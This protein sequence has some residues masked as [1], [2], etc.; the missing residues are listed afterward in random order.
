L[1]ETRSELAVPLIVG[2]Q[3]LGVLDVQSD[4]VGAFD[5]EDLFI[6][7][8]LA[9]QIAIAIEDARL[10]ASQKEEAW[11]LNVLLQVAENLSAT[12]NLDD[13]LETV[14]RITP[15][16]VGVARCAI[17][18]YDPREQVFRPAKSYGL[19][20]ALQEKFRRLVFPL[21]SDTPDV[22]GE[23]W[24]T[25]SPVQIENVQ[26][27]AL[28]DQELARTFELESMLIVP[29]MT[30]GEIVGAMAVDQGPSPRRFTSHEMQVLMGIANQAAVAIV[31]AR[32]NEEAEVKKRLDYELGLAR[33]IQASFL[34]DRVPQVAGF[35]IASAWRAAREVSG[36]F[37]DFMNL[38][39]GRV[40]FS[41]ADVSD[42]GMP[43]SLFM[44]LTRTL[45]RAMAIGKPTP[46]EAL[47]RANDLII[48][49]ARTDMFVTA[50]YG[51][52]DPATA[53]FSFTNAGHNPPLWFRH[54]EEVLTTLR[55]HGLALGVHPNIDLPEEKVELGPGD[56][57]LM[58]T[59]GIT[60]ALNPREEEFGIGRLADLV[61][62]NGQLS[63][64]E[65]VSEILRAVDDFSEG[66]PQF[67]DLTMA[68]LKRKR[69]GSR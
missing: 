15:I 1:D 51:V 50:L 34:P 32:L 30:R 17:F 16:L 25:R 55:A 41:I 3:L 22:F 64:Q 44:V 67:D 14:V 26:E 42:K 53:E 28:V 65:L 36:D 6:L 61:A 20:P 62:V 39:E 58:Y 31:S 47:E 40:G 18:L 69:N 23:M 66:A 49:D 8:T 48:S 59:D 9:A 2:Q 19:S 56:T 38:P 10:Y 33:Q 60:D 37:Y 52:L 29:L 43:A 35:D 68:V 63:A 13:A 7:K 54:D 27:S 4:E 45:I 46:R 12:T 5:E 24:T 11:Y 21:Q 57:I